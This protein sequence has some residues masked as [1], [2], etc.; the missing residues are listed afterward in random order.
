VQDVDALGLEHGMTIGLATRV[1]RRIVLRTIGKQAVQR[2][3]IA[4]AALFGIDLVLAGYQSIGILNYENSETSGEDYL[5]GEV[6]PRLIKSQ[7]PV[8]FDIGANRGEMSL[9]LRQ[10]FPYARIMAFE[11]NPITYAALTRNTTLHKIE[12]IRAGMG[13]AAGKGVLHCYRDDPTS[14]HATVYRDMF[15][16]YQG[17]GIAA[18]SDL[19][20]FEF[21]IQT[22]DDVCGTLNIE[23]IAFL[24][25]DVEGHELEVLKGARELLADNRIDL[26]QFE[27]T[28]CN[29][30]SRTYM[31]D[32]YEVLEGFRL[33]RLGPGQ[34]IPLGPYAARLEVFQ[35]QNIL[36]A[37]SDIDV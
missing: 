24:K 2:Y 23:R 7:H 35:F 25:I 3:L 6:L 1:I 29:V 33:F 16:L 37:R 31:R 10:S 34:L 5:I 15:Q 28:D 30:L 12:C 14:G 13:S 4:T 8:I 18:A 9:A 19:T 22:L 11:P 26:V 32:F 20:A 17:Y 27:F 21:P 36:A